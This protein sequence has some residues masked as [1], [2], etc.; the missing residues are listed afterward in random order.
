MVSALGLGPA[1][2]VL[3]EFLLCLPNRSVDSLQHRPLLGAA[4]IR[5]GHGHQLERADPAGAG[6]VRA[7]AQ[8]HER[9]VLVGRG[10]RQRLA[11][12]LRLRGEVVEDLDLERLVALLEERATLC[13]REL[14]AN[15]RVVGLDR[16]THAVL[17]RGEVVRRQRA[18]QQEVVVEAVGD[19]RPD[20]ELS[21]GED[22]LYGL[23]HHVRG[24]VAHRVEVTVGPGVEELVGRAAFDDIELLIGLHRRARSRRGCLRLV[25]LAHLFSDAV[26][27]LSRSV[28]AAAR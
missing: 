24:R 9:T 15:E 26:W 4:P 7:L 12:L 16:G 19:C 27:P 13:R 21:V 14:L 10:G 28:S 17:D 25:F 23:G 22:A 20:T 8:V 1:F 3:V 5:P 6:H 11:A 2:E 18:G